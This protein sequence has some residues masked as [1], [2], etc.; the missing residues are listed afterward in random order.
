MKEKIYEEI[1]DILKEISEDGIDEIK[2]DEDLKE[3]GINSLVFIQMLVSLEEKYD[4][5]FEDE[6]LDQEK[7]S[8]IDAVADYV[9]KMIRE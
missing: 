4:F 1:I 6:M 9:L 8:N 5:V 3:K 7:L 2:I